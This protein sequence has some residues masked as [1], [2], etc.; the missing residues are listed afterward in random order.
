M[1]PTSFGAALRDL[2][3][4][5]GWSLRQFA[6]SVHYSAPYISEIE[7]GIKR[8]TAE[9]ARRCDAAVGAG[10]EL[11]A[12][13]V[14]DDQPP[15]Q[16]AVVGF[17][18]P[19]VSVSEVAMAA[20]HEST[21]GAVDDGAHAV[22]TIGI[23]QV[24]STATRLARDYNDQPP[25]STLLAARDLRE[26][27]RKM[28][29]TTR[30]PRQSAD[31]YQVAG[32]ACGIMSIASFDLGIWP[33]AMEQARAT[34]VYADVV[35]DTSLRAWAH[36][37]LAFTAFWFG[38]PLE[39][40]DYAE[41]GLLDA[42]AGTPRARLHSIA[43]RAWSHLGDADRARAAIELAAREREAST[44][45]DPL[46]DGIGGQF[47]WGPARQAMCEANTWLQLRHS[48]GA[49]SAA[50]EAIQLRAG[51]GTGT[52]V[53]VKASVDLASA[54]LLRG[55]LDAVEAALTPAW[56]VGT[57]FREHTL[58]SRLERV[59]A[60]LQEPRHRSAPEARRLHDRIGAFVEASAPRALPP[61]SDQIA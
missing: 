33:A 26:L 43:A 39:A 34:V 15:G 37:T 59:G 42:P 25:L 20:A 52:L 16:S 6:E 29:E 49:V 21:T 56:S 7:R 36:G 54:E 32:Q 22:P 13:A 3:L 2:R 28:A 12:R 24:R 19:H 27:A 53:D 46:H 51:D 4:R 60:Q 50:R 8:P 14:A 41:R 5:Q 35:D 30:K 31:L 9:V 11:V 45:D 61:G 38:H 47:G 55:R 58:V 23:E 1:G 48:D 18:E 17:A 40:T 44:G 10:G 57:R